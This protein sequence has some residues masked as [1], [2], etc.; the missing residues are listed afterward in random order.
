LAETER[1]L[2]AKEREVAAAQ[3]LLTGMGAKRPLPL[4]DSLRI[5]SPCKAQWEEMVGDE[6][7]R[8]CGQCSK[9]VY[10]LSAMSREDAEELVRAKEGNLCARMVQRSD[11]TVMSAD[12]PVGARKKRVRRTAIAVVSGGLIA[13]GV[14]SVS[15]ARIGEVHPEVRPVQGEHVMGALFVKPPPA[16]DTPPSA[17]PAPLPSR[18]TPEALGRTT[19]GTVQATKSR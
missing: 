12:C 9:N 4:L 14:L 15:T 2:R 10:N 19:L 6:R 16:H 11:G 3:R 13:S 17:E 7:V 18:V 5:A 8:F 1:A